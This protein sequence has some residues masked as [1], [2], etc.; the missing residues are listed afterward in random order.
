M[1]DAATLDSPGLTPGG[2]LHGAAGDHDACRAD[3][4]RYAVLQ[5]VAPML[6]HDLA[7]A[8]QPIS[9]IAVVLQRRLQMPEPDLAALGK[10]A[11]NVGTLVKEASAG[12]LDAMDWLA[13]RED[14]A[15]EVEAGVS[16]ILKLLGVEL[17]TRNLD[18]AMDIP[19]HTVA[20]PQ[21]FFRTVLAG[22]LFA[23]ADE[24]RGG[25]LHIGFE[26]DSQPS[27]GGNGSLMLRVAAGNDDA[28]IESLSPGQ[29]GGKFRRIG[30]T[31]VEAMA[32]SFGATTSRGEGWVS[33]GLPG[34]R[35]Q[36][37]G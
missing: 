22:A 12:C 27:V 29:P 8:L 5:R 32:E 16:G 9:M 13:P 23:L 11:T 4:A 15:I 30:W 37:A 28:A 6:R 36:V 19:A 2:R 3:A 24:G 14:T 1:T 21:S 18:A 20:V 7:G 10:T 25:T 26:P 34:R 31:D 35:M 17:T 33:L